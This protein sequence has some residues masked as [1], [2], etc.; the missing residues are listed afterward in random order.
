MSLLV[1]INVDNSIESP[2]NVIDIY[3]DI[4]GKVILNY[5]ITL[6]A[7]FKHNEHN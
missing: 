5:N 1:L 6:D 4:Q 2:V 3:Q 7:V